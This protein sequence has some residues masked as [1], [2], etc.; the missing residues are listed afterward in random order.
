MTDDP[1]LGEVARRLDHV[2]TQLTALV[3][4]LEARDRYVEEHFVRTQ[5]WLEAR[6]ADQAAVANLHQD[7][8][9]L[10]KDRDNDANFRRQIFLIAL[11]ALA[12]GIVAVFIALVGLR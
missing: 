10:Q 9:G 8:G 4:R 5:V 1:T 3:D 6:K 11:G 7:I 2:V 12:S